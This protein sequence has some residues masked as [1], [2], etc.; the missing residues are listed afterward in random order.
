[1][2]PK[3]ECRR[4]GGKA[5]RVARGILYEPTDSADSQRMLLLLKRTMRRYE[6]RLQP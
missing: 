5:W 6:C 4:K 2:K 1:M 3:I